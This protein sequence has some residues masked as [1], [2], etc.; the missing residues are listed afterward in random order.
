MEICEN[1]CLP[2]PRIP[3]LRQSNGYIKRNLWVWR[4]QKCI[5]LL[6]VE[7]VLTSIG[8]Q[9]TSFQGGQYRG[10]IGPRMEICVNS[11][12]PI[13]MLPC[14]HKRNVYLERKIRI[15]RVKKCIVLVH[16]KSPPT[17]AG[18][19]TTP[20]HWGHYRAENGNMRKFG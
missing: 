18:L 15:W 14:F 12:L 5:A 3:R 6:G 13:G 2:I 8:P 16:G 7:T 4:A 20:F 19:Q 9:T 1:L 10:S 17:C 11:G